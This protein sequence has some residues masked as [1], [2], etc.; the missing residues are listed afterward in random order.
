[1][2]RVKG[3]GRRER[4]QAWGV[5]GSTPRSGAHRDKVHPAIRRIRQRGSSFPLPEAPVKGEE[6]EMVAVVDS[7]RS[8]TEVAAAVV[9]KV[10]KTR[11]KVYQ[12]ECARARIHSKT[13]LLR[14]VAEIRKEEGEVPG[15]KGEL[16]LADALRQ[17]A[18]KPSPMRTLVLKDYFSGTPEY[19]VVFFEE[20][21]LQE[22][23]TFIRRVLKR[24][25]LAKAA[26][27]CPGYGE[28]GYDAQDVR[29]TRLREFGGPFSGLK[30]WS[31]RLGELQPDNRKAGSDGGDSDFD[32]DRYLES[33]TGDYGNVYGDNDG[34]S[35][36]EVFEWQAER[37]WE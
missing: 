36:D 34:P 14:A 9:P 29:R 4:T 5:N 1:M 25:R 19:V 18:R 30:G 33:P 16:E 22:L 7:T 27:A 35:A 6:S 24:A 23:K 11:R 21:I 28:P 3:P 15:A 31:T 17:L 26:S 32:Y 37:G 13:E 10:E 20:K 12:E 2:T 8:M